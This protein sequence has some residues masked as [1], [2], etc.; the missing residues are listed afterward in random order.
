MRAAPLIVGSRGFDQ[1]I[2]SVLRSAFDVTEGVSIGCLG[3]APIPLG[4][5]G[6]LGY[7]LFWIVAA[8]GSCVFA[9]FDT[10][11]TRAFASVEWM[12]GPQWWHA[13]LMRSFHRYASDLMIVVMLLHM[14]RNSHLDRFRGARWFHHGSPGA[15]DRLPLC[16]RH[17]RLLAGVGQARPICGDNIDGTDRLDADLRRADRA[18]FPRAVRPVGRVLHASGL[19]AREL[20]IVLLFVMW[21][22]PADIASKINPPRCSARRTRRPA[23][24]VA[25][26]PA[27]AGSRR[28]CAD[29]DTGKGKFLHLIL[30]ARWPTVLR[31][32]LGHNDG[33]RRCAVDRAVSAAAAPTGHRQ[34]F[35]D[36][37]LQRLRPDA[38]RIAL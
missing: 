3:R 24:R 19:S 9:L 30:Y 35:L 10:G 6:A 29:P 21:I 23:G 1:G 18:E 20:P 25:G 15:A 16:L 38:S 4:Q 22:H 36:D 37:H 33:H 7:F 28:S 13:G 8:S 26:V 11:V 32:R 27:V 34:V 12:S 2:Q 17:Y 31:A 5:L 14:T